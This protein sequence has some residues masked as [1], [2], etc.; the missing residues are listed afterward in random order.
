MGC[1]PSK[2]LATTSNV[3]PVESGLKSTQ[4]SSLYNQQSGRIIEDCIIIWFL[5][6]STIDAEL[7][8]LKL[9]RIASTVKIFTN[10]DV[11]IN[12]ITN[13]R[14]EVVFLI[15][16][17][18]EICVPS[19]RNSTKIE[20]T[21][22]FNSSSAELGTDGS[23]N[24]NVSLNIF[25]DIHC[26][27]QQ[28][29]TDIK[30]YRLDNLV[31][32]VAAPLS[33]TDTT[34]VDRKKQEASFLYG[35]LMREILYR[36]KFENN[37]KNEFIKF[38]RSHYTH[39]LEQ[40]SVIDEFE[41]LYQPQKA[42]WW[43][44]RPC[45]IHR[46]LQRIQS[47]FEIDI[48]YKSGF[49]LKH[50]HTLL[51]V[52]QE[53]NSYVPENVSIVYRGKTMINNQFESLIKN[54]RGGLLSFHNIFI[55]HTDKGNSI[56]FLRRRLISIPD[57]I[58]ILFEI[59]MN[60]LVRSIRS[61][62][63]VLDKLD[64]H[65]NIEKNG[66]IFSSN[67]V[68]RIDSIEAFNED[69]KTTIWTVKLMLI[70][71]DDQQLLSLVAHLRGD[72]IHANPLAYIGKLF[73]DME[74]YEHAEQFFVAMLHDSSVC[75]QPRRLARVHHGLGDNYANRGHYEKALKHYEQALDARL[76]YLPSIHIELAPIYE[77]IGKTYFS[78]NDYSKALE[79]YEKVIHL[80]QVN[81]QNNNQEYIND[82]YIRID[83]LKNLLDKN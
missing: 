5:N 41:R 61:P 83:H 10:Y 37:A 12:Y 68:F 3:V 33:K 24:I 44:T 47:T 4:T 77:A 29:E 43:L 31:I 51:T 62:C 39:E 18:T 34:S 38:C 72:D 49:I 6:S 59:H 64:I 42:L 8:K 11:F 32:A 16:P 67:T 50:A 15:V 80:F 52:F 19:I 40:L 2:T 48:V 36:F 13:I 30:L 9:C 60:S 35:Q 57:A 14:S 76:I 81:G 17:N 69:S 54:N 27:C 74:E 1:S 23:K 7:G 70:D 21:Y 26:L 46:I 25:N 63:A 75:G 73:N 82:L 58:S 22:V 65:E 45:F 20:K 55:A 78:M 71:D 79:N 56:N 28:L 66:I 53:N